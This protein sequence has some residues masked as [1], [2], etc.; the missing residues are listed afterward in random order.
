MRFKN[1]EEAGEQLAGLIHRSG[2]KIDLVIGLPRGG[3]LAAQ[4][5]AEKLDL[6]MDYVLVKKI[7]PP[8]NPEYAIA[9]IS[10]DGEILRGDDFFTF[11]QI[12]E[13]YLTK[14][15]SHY[16]QEL[17]AR[18]DTYRKILPRRE[19]KN[20]KIL[21]VDDGLATGL[22]VEAAVDYLLRE[23]AEEVYVAAPVASF[24]ALERL[25]KKAKD[26]FII[27]T[28]DI[29]YAVGEFYQEFYPISEESVL[30]ILKKE[31]DR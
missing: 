27:H 31:R 14:T 19:V 5:V 21:V 17:T 24:E 3:L 28:P 8:G 7:G 6:P 10:L 11:S 22:T 2:L 30:D 1:R 9:I 23:G 12:S 25:K 13:T 26:I 15:A 18:D 16:L 29:F 4:A 20:K